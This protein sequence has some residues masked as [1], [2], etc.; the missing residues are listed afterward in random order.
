MVFL[1][2]KPEGCNDLVTVMWHSEKINIKIEYM[3]SVKFS[4]R[5]I[6]PD[7]RNYGNRLLK[8]VSFDLGLGFGYTLNGSYPRSMC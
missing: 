4:E 2:C 7:N 1:R 8:W 3:I 5:W 6:Y